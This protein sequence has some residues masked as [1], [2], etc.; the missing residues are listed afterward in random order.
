M[1]TY[2]LFNFQIILIIEG[3]A[4]SEFIEILVRLVLLSY[5][6]P[7]SFMISISHDSFQVGLAKVDIRTIKQD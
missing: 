7:H 2:I 6:V 5:Q 3:T 4:Y 1:E